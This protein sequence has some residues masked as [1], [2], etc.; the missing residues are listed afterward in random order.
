MLKLEGNKLGDEA[1]K[2]LGAA[3]F[4]PYGYWQTPQ[5]PKPIESRT[6]YD[7][8]HIMLMCAHAAHGCSVLTSAHASAQTEVLTHQPPS[9]HECSR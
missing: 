4:I 8:N 1:A 2:A 6:A 9:T 7:S 3:Y 5:S